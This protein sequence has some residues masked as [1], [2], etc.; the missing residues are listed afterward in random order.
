MNNKITFTAFLQDEYSKKFDQLAGRTDSGIK[1]IE[2]DFL[3]LGNTGKL[4]TRNI[5]EL[6]KRIDVLTKVRRMTV[7]TSAIKFATREIKNLQKEKERLEGTGTRSGGGSSIINIASGV[8]IAQYAPR[9]IGMVTDLFK[10]TI[11]ASM[12]REQQRISLGVLMGGQKQGDDMLGKVASMAA[13]TPFGTNDLLKATQTMLGFGVSQE[14]VLPIMNQVGD[15]SGGN[16][17]RF[18]SLT[19][20]FSQMSS[21]GR[22]MGQDLL[23]MVNAGFNPLNE[24]SKMTGKSMAT[25]KK[26]MEDGKISAELVMQAMSK[27]T[28]EGGLYNGMMEKQSQTTAGRLS[29]LKDEYNEMAVAIGQKFKPEI[30]L[31]IGALSSMVATVRG[32]VE[33]PLS[34]KLDEETKNLEKLRAELGFSNT[35][36]NRRKQILK[37]LKAI[38]PD[39]VD[40]TK[41]EKEQLDKLNGSLDTYIAKRRKQ[42]MMEQIK[43]QNLSAVT[44]YQKGE[45]QMEESYTKSLVAVGMAK[46]V[47]FKSD[48][49]SIGQ[50]Q[51]GAKSFLENR[52]A[53]GQETNYREVTQVIPG[54][55]SAGVS[56]THKFSDEREALQLYKAQ[57]RANKQGKEL[58]KENKEGYLKYQQTIKEVDALF[59]KIEEKKNQ[60]VV[61]DPNDPNDR[62]K[63]GPSSSPSISGGS[64]VKNITINIDSLV[65]G[66]VNVSSTTLKESAAQIKDLVIETLLTAVNDSNLAVGN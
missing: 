49:L 54:V 16:V 13:R 38:Q 5:D 1:K 23:Q 44:A 53:S 40:G 51:I 60:V 9:A 26:E 59:G 21:T 22:L 25:L 14:K 12:E 36:E 52:I 39:I 45:K 58:I 20:A 63:L 41:S 32:F 18:Q 48:G 11:N 15:I 37:E 3:K 62:N 2:K 29:T 46:R 43:E 35:T 64:Q 30:D 47:G 10:D 6:N 27:A 4:A 55:G 28:S 57:E 33:I 31:A 34:K 17:D 61:I 19:L 7:D 65:K 56:V 24:I 50:A 66:G 8:G 42:I